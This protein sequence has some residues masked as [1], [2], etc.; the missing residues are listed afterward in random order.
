M[1]KTFFKLLL[2]VI[3]YTVVFLIGTGIL[4]HTQ[5]FR[6]MKQPDNPFGLLFLLINSAFV[7]FVVYFIIKNSMING[8]KLFLISAGV[9]FFV[10]SF[11]TQI[12]TLF[13]IRVFKGLMVL[14][15]MLFLV[16]DLIALAATT[17]LMIKF[18]QNKEIVCEA[19]KIDVRSV[20]IKLGIIGIIY[21][22]VYMIFGYFVA[23]QFEALRLFYSGSAEKLSF[24]GQLANNIK[25]NPV[26]YPFQFI[27]GILFSGA[28][29]PLLF[30]NNKK[31]IFIFSVCLVYF[32][33]S[34]VLLIPNALFPDMVRYGHLIEM[35]TS[36][37][38][39][40]LIAGNIM[41]AK[42][43]NSVLPV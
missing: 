4:P 29:L 16:R 18:F 35:S 11:M 22:F 5:E 31:K 9:V 33:T 12:E 13:F 30:V 1:V 17:P 43:A 2:C 24:I 3:I 21:T 39:F 38:V 36:M 6:E 25:T 42:N 14:D 26:I 27:R 19:I 37:T 7:C 28:I 15:V 41:Y 23:W 32:S 8:I 20:I 40:G 34:A 10:Q